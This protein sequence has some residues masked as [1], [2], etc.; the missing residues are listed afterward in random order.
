LL[1][2]LSFGLR[3]TRQFP[4]AIAARVREKSARSP[5]EVREIPADG[6]EYS[7]IGETPRASDPERPDARLGEGLGIPVDQ[8]PGAIMNIEY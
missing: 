3:E 6:G 4:S 2:I 8:I 5:R 7:S 1:G